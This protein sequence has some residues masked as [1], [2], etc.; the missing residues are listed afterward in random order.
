MDD[1]Q[2]QNRRLHLILGV[3]TD[4][5]GLNDHTTCDYIIS[6]TESLSRATSLRKRHLHPEDWQYSNYAS[7]TMGMVLTSC[8][9]YDGLPFFTLHGVGTR[10]DHARE[11]PKKEQQ[12]DVL[13]DICEHALEWRNAYYELF[14]SPSRLVSVTIG[15][16]TFDFVNSVDLV[17]HFA[18]L[19]KPLFRPTKNIPKFDM[20]LHD[21]ISIFDGLYGEV[22]VLVNKSELEKKIEQDLETLTNARIKENYTTPGLR[23]HC[24]SSLISPPRIPKRPAALSPPIVRPRRRASSL[25]PSQHFGGPSSSLHTSSS[26]QNPSTSRIN[27]SPESPPSPLSKRI[28]IRRRHSFSAP[29]TS[30]PPPP[31]PRH[32]QLREGSDGGAH[33]R[34]TLSA[35]EGW[36]KALEQQQKGEGDEGE[37]ANPQPL[38][39]RRFIKSKKGKG[40]ERARGDGDENEG[41][42]TKEGKGTSSRAKGV[43][44]GVK[45]LGLALSAV[46]YPNRISSLNNLIIPGEHLHGFR[47]SSDWSLTDDSM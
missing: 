36:K 35:L 2:S 23:N 33:L 46:T 12:E 47:F 22:D 42:E 38:K 11:L 7:S 6:R 18:K 45:D 16:R 29:S 3:D 44:A 17:H 25:P 9:H 37:D 43:G 40:K 20:N 32:Y 31:R 28:P 41:D 10:K 30:S 13:F 15:G 39:K 26:P 4:H 19:V 1:L 5:A 8:D 34:G 14:K 21:V 27:P 24:Y